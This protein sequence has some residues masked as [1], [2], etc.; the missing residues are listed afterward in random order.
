MFGG[1]G[2]FR[3]GVMFALIAYE[4]L[5]FRVDELSEPDFES[6]GL[7]RFVYEKPGG[8]AMSMSYC[9]A[10]PDAYDAPGI[11]QEWAEKGFAAA[12]RVDA[13][14]PKSKQKRSR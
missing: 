1:V 11:M 2:F 9:K 4:E 7:G 3:E 10:P 6:L 14:K 5:Y 13:A 12:C 8:K